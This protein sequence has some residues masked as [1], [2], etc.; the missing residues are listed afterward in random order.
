MVSWKGALV[1]L[2]LLAGLVV[3]A[4]ATRPGPAPVLHI[5]SLIPCN[6]QTLL[7][8]QID[9]AAGGQFLAD[10]PDL[11]TP[12]TVRKPVT[13]RAEANA[14]SVLEQ[15][16]DSIEAQNTI[17]DPG[18]PAQYGLD[19]PR[20]TVTCRVTNG[21][22]YTLSVGGESF[23]K[24]GYYARKSGS[25]EVYVISSVQVDEFDRVLNEPPVEQSP[26][27]SGPSP[28]PTH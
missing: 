7:S 9:Y 10:R 18:P 14:I 19:K 24:A 15:S 5:K 20:L 3:Y 21:S 28:A 2:A 27:P 22:S 13:G 16:L 25:G 26:L 8:I 1:V 11:A 17:R 4:V 6:S 12:W 23:D